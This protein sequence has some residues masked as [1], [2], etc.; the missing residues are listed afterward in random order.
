MVVEHRELQAK[1]S[2]NP[3]DPVDA[4]GQTLAVTQSMARAGRAAGGAPGGQPVF[5][6]STL[7][8]V[9]TE[10]LGAGSSS[11]GGRYGGGRRGGVHGR[12]GVR[13]RRLGL[14]L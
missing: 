7:V 11:G 5:D 13:G 14:E 3:D 8:E 4:P 6:V 10:Y 12:G 1:L 9:K 2:R